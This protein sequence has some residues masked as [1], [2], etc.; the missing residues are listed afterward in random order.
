MEEGRVCGGAFKRGAPQ[1]SNSGCGV[2]L[3]KLELNFSSKFKT[4]CAWPL[5]CQRGVCRAGRLVNASGMAMLGRCWQHRC[6][7]GGVA[8]YMH[9]RGLFQH[10]L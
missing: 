8:M 7:S 4:A 1:R 5:S 6:E 10:R 9:I 3:I 2:L